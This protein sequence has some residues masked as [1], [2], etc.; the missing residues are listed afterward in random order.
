MADQV[1][2]SIIVKGSVDE[3][4]DIWSDF[5]T[6][7]QYMS[8]IE[9]VTP[10]SDGLSH[11]VMKGPLGANFEWDAK[12]TLMEENSR[13]AWRS[14]DGSM[15]TSGQVSFKALPHDQTQVTVTLQYVPPRGTAGEIA[16]ALF[17]RPE[18]RLSEDLRNFKAFVEQTTRAA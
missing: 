7:P 1:T 4:Y 11:W 14:V 9:S 16:A 3:L 10:R 18:Q 5:T 12:T 6:F 17:A 13:I 15:K 2:K 8:N